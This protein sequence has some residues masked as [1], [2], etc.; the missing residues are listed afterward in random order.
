MLF[1]SILVPYRIA[2]GSLKPTKQS[3]QSTL[4]IMAVHLLF[5]MLISVVFVP[6]L[7]GL[8]AAQFGG[9]PAAP[10][11]L[12]GTLVLVGGFAAL[13]G[14]TL[15]PLSRLLLRRETKILRAVTEV[16]E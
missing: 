16:N 4:A 15:R 10:V 2:S 14:F 11:N 13:Y 1:R 6:P 7:A 9:L 5:P 12:L 3:W 8:L